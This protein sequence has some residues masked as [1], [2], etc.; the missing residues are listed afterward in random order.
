MTLDTTAFGLNLHL[1]DAVGNLRQRALVPGWP[2]LRFEWASS[3]AIDAEWGGANVESLIA[4]P[5]ADDDRQLLVQ[6][7]ASRYRLRLGSVGDYLLA[8]D[9][10]LACAPVAAADQATWER[11][12]GA[13]VLPLASVLAGREVLHASAVAMD[14][15]VVAF[16]GR[17][18]VGKSTVAARLVLAGAQ[19]YCDDV[20]AVA[21]GR[22][23]VVAFPGLGQLR[24]E[25]STATELE[26]PLPAAWRG[27]IP[28]ATGKLCL[29][30]DVPSGS[31]S[32][33]AIYL[34][35]RTAADALTVT[36]SRAAQDLIGATFNLIVRTPERLLHHL[37]VCSRIS[38]RVPVFRVVVPAGA[39][40]YDV[41]GRLAEH[42][43]TYL[44]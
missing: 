3:R 12:L 31:H 30:V 6:R 11:F 39:D 37:D 8:G 25:P 2:S 29:P 44:R 41:S 9:G 22:D 26:A 21:A 5:L 43:C 27:T 34:L 4:A 32:L 18:G 20:V 16:A 33:D 19:P 15:L 36:A 13:Q 23:E 28:D 42:A 24:L 38:A 10:R 14:G 35:E 1:P 7:A 17:S 40:A